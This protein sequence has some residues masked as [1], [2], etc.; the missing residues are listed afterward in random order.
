MHGEQIR[1]S[2]DWNNLLIQP[3]C[4]QL[5]QQSKKTQD[6]TEGYWKMDKII[7]KKS[8]YNYSF[9]KVSGEGYMN[10]KGEPITKKTILQ[11]VRKFT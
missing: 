5:S 4:I 10:G 8:K 11:A 1:F 2:L 9:T 3:K 6:N 7:E